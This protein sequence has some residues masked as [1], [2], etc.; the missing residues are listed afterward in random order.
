MWPSAALDR[1]KTSEDGQ[2]ARKV[3]DV[4]RID[5]FAQTL[6]EQPYTA[7]LALSLLA[8]MF[9]QSLSERG[10]TLAESM[11]SLDEMEQATAE[12]SGGEQL[13]AI[14][15][16]ELRSALAFGWHVPAAI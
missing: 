16:S 9:G 10:L 13:P 1:A 7:R 4:N 12:T 5:A 14:F 15:W 8:Q 3:S 6:R 11:A 2:A